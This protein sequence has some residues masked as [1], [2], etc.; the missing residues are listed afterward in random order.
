MVVPLVHKGELLGV[1]NVSAAPERVFDE[2]DLHVLALFAEPVAAALANARLFEAERNHVARLVELDRMK[3]QFVAT[4][5]H[6]LRT[7]LTSIRGALG[8]I[9]RD[10]PAEQR[11][12]LLDVIDRQTARLS[13][14]VEEMLQTAR[15]ER[16]Q[17][18]P[19]LRRIDLSALVR[20][21][22]LDCQV[23][24]RPVQ[25]EAPP[26][27]EVR[28]DPEAM[29]RVVSNL[30]EN[31]HKYGLPPV[32]VVVAKEADRV[33][34]SVIDRGPGVPAED[35]E[36]IF[37]RF[38]RAERTK[39]QPGLGLG[40]AIVRGLVESC[41]GQVWV[42]DAPG[43]GAMFRVALRTRFAAEQPAKGVEECAVSGS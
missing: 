24:D 37:E 6:E 40:L 41:G 11:A 4:V 20:L 34:L 7:P 31:A 16:D 39:S 27:C 29:R 2:Y 13:E 19:K 23:A 30:V 1:L 17:Q 12:E 32:T 36:R 22:A 38:H 42:E 26:T 3:S 10:L 14:M 5:S 18:L 43:G 9:R 21:V 35:R 25:V 8:A 15:L 33:V 28:T